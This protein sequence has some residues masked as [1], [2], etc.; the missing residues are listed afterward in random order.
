M[1][2][3]TTPNKIPYSE[4]PVDDS[5]IHMQQN[6]MTCYSEHCRII[7]PIYWH[8]AIVYGIMHPQQINETIMPLPQ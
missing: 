8:S 3:L 1:E 2:K 4:Q 6:T 7:F 5:H